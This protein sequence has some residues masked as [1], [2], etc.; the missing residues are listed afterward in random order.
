MR[1]LRPTRSTVRVYAAANVSQ[2]FAAACL[3]TPQ[4]SA[5]WHWG[6]AIMISVIGLSPAA[7][8]TT[9]APPSPAPSIG[10]SDAYPPGYG[11]QPLPSPNNGFDQ[12]N[13]S[14]PA[15]SSLGS[16]SPAPSSNSTSGGTLVS[17]P[18]ELQSLLSLGGVPT[19]VAQL[20][21]MEAQ[22]TKVSKL[23]DS[24]TVSV[25]IGPAQGCGVIITES[26]FVLT[27]AHVA[28]RPGKLAMVTLSDGRT[29]RATTLGM[30][31]NVDAGL[32]KIELNQNGGRPWPHASLGTS[33]DLVAGMWCIATGHPGGYDPNR[34]TV[35]RVGRILRVRE[36]AI[37]TDCALIGG[38]SGGPLFDLSGRLIAVHS[39]IGNDVAE[40]LHVPVDFYGTS[41]DRMRQNDAWGFL[42]GFRP[43]LG[44]TGSPSL[45][46][47]VIE[48][49][50]TGSPAEEAGMQVGDIIEQFG[51][52][53]ISDFASLKTAVADTMPG[54]RVSV[55]LNRSNDRIRVSVEVGRA[56]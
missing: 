6:V 4:S 32:M 37:E 54:E 45:K 30:N 53:V 1:L 34:S 35:T 41:W 42:P 9:F 33:K 52:V 49:V 47:A 23:A 46:R 3:R 27:A 14:S 55:W 51:D 8:Q 22:Q 26:G 2:L 24:C 5:A 38:D 20:R 29:V 13:Y 21:L 39:R 11:N 25:Q 31:R 40:N 36:G 10:I 12:R 18:S 16:A 15:P 50:R 56:D 7:A 48:I 19:S 43:V 44:V 17:V 28:M